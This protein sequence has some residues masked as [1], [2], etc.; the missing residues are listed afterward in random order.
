[1]EKIKIE[2]LPKDQKIS[3][4]EMRMV[5]GGTLGD[6]SGL[7]NVH[8]QNMLQKQ[9]QTMQMMATPVRGLYDTAIATIRKMGG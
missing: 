9:Y 6:D 5:L 4:E 2:D 1:M 7:E 3:M 8:L